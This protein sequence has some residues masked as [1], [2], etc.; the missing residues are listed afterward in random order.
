MIYVQFIIYII[1]LYLF[2][3][4]SILVNCI[5]IMNTIA[6]YLFISTIYTNN[7]IVNNK[8]KKNILDDYNK[9]III[10]ND[11]MIKIIKK[12]NINITDDMSLTIYD[13]YTLFILIEL[14]YNCMKIIFQL[15]N[16]LNVNKI[17]KIIMTLGGLPIIQLILFSNNKFINI[18]NVIYKKIYNLYASLLSKITSRFLNN[19][20]E[21]CLEINTNIEANELIDFFEF[22]QTNKINIIIFLKILVLQLILNY[23]RKTDNIIYKYIIDL[24]YK[25]KVE[26]LIKYKYNDDNDDNN[27]SNEYKK[28]YLIELITERKWNLLLQYNTINIL[29]DI[30]NKKDYDFYKFG[31][32]LKNININFVRFIS[33]W[34]LSVISPLFT[35]FVDIYNSLFPLIFMNNFNKNNYLAYISGSLFLYFEYNLYGAFIMV[36][37]EYLLTPILDYINDN[38]IVNWYNIFY[39]IIIYY[40]EYYSIIL[41]FLFK[42]LSYDIKIII[43][44]N[45]IINYRI[46]NLVLSWILINLLIKYYNDEVKI[47][48]LN[49]IDNYIKKEVNEIDKIIQL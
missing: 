38:K 15:D 22:S 2:E 30:Y 14:I 8:I 7:K 46:E 1:V 18:I 20:C 28:K 39:L 17:L 5:N 33:I 44:L 4:N 32:I 13:Q 36:F 29:I 12:I 19:I 37:G 9:K 40:L 45:L 26:S 27:I 11:S 34:S 3:N 16:Y 10:E 42:Y 24:I 49:I 25:F 6:A 47:I 48:K 41:F 31:L 43:L 21:N 23:Y 35:I